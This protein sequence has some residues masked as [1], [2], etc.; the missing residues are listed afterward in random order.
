MGRK[1]VLDGGVKVGD[2]RAAE[3]I[4]VTPSVKMVVLR[5]SRRETAKRVGQRLDEPGV[6]VW[7][8][9]DEARVAEHPLK[10]SGAAAPARREYKNRR[11]IAVVH[12]SR[13][14]LRHR[15]QHLTRFT[16]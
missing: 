16:A 12:D 13:P 14:T 1:Q 2:E 11:F 9:P 15:G 7:L 5:P 10:H 4:P 3:L 6:A 8:T